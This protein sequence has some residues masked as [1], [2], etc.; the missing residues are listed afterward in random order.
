MD[1]TGKNGQPSM[2]EILASIR[3][4]IAEEPA[5]AISLD[6]K[7]RTGPV[8]GN[9]AEHLSLDDSSDFEL[10]SMFRASPAA[11]GTDKAPGPA[12]KLM[13]ALRATP[14]LNADAAARTQPEFPLP[15]NLGG[16]LDAAM[17]QLKT[18]TQP[19][20]GPQFALSTLRP[21]ARSE[22]PGGDLNGHASSAYTMPAVEAV[23]A[24]PLADALWAAEQVSADPIQTAEPSS[25]TVVR[26]MV[27]FK[28]QH[29][30]R[31]FGGSAAPA[32][33]KPAPEQPDTVT[34]LPAV[35]PPAET[36]AYSAPSRAPSFAN[37]AIQPPVMPPPLTGYVAQTAAAPQ[38]PVVP[39]ATSVSANPVG[40]AIEDA[41]AELLRPMLRQ[42]L[43]DNMPR[44]VEKAL[45]IEVAESVKPGKKPGSI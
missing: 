18:E 39:M 41:T 16:G 7:P 28:D 33:P 32:Q 4:I 26:E 30:S 25:S 6:F 5:D 8:P 29:F 3:R 40:G 34:A 42:W 15:S 27:P 45:H 38:Q 22:A 43:S 13:D 10:P 19:V 36:S 9:G 37:L 21:T 11:A 14:Q 2:E 44:M 12:V 31:M 17:N 1:M 35:A 23:P 24:A 20:P